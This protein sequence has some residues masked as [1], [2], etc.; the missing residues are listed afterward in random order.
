M[1]YSVYYFSAYHLDY[2]YD[3]LNHEAKWTIL[4]QCGSFSIVRHLKMAI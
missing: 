3:V 4:V 2:D 1:N